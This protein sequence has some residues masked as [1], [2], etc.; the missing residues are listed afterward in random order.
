M[1]LEFDADGVDLVNTTVSAI[2]DAVHRI[3]KAEGGIGAGQ[4]ARLEAA[5]RDLQ[6]ALDLKKTAGSRSSQ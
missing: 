2:K 4:I 3:G 1:L 6:H 5:M